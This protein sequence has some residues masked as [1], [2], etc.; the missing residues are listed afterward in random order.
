MGKQKVS[1]VFKFKIYYNRATNQPIGPLNSPN[2][3]VIADIDKPLPPPINALPA[4][5]EIRYADLV[6]YEKEK[7]K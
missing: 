7:K 3:L 6:V 4:E 2:Y 1:K 5:V